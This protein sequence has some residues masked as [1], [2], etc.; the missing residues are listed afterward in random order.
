MKTKTQIPQKKFLNFLR[1][2]TVKSLVTTVGATTA[3]ATTLSFAPVAQAIT[4]FTDQTAWENALSGA[5]FETE[6]FDGAASSFDANSTGNVIGS[7]LTVDL[8][9]GVGD[10]GPTGL[11][12][13]GFFLGEVDASGDDALTLK[14]NTGSAVTGFGILGWQ[15]DEPDGDAPPGGGLDLEEYGIEVNG[16]RFLLSDILGLTNSS[17][18]NPIED[19]INS[20]GPIPF[21]GFISDT[22]IT[23]FS[24]LHGDLV[25][26]AGVSGSSDDFLMD[27]IVIASTTPASTPEPASILGLLAVGAVGAASKLKRKQ[28]YHLSKKLR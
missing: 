12:G 17:D 25:V 24:L 7:F 28:S 27:G 19:S 21:V 3:I 10:T 2:Q 8:I 22:Q 23:S 4:V 9:G 6:N 11:T 15:N 18:G 1:S 5:S 13:D 14:F 20:S 16:D 26:P